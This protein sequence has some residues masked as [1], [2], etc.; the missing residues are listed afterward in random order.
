MLEFGKKV[1]TGVGSGQ[2]VPTVEPQSD[3][4]RVICGANIQEL[5]GMLGYTIREVR[6]NLKEILNIGD[7]HTTVLVNGRR[8]TG[9][10]ALLDGNEEL[11]F[12]KPAGQKG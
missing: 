5:D 2:E 9:E 10:G 12:K 11:E 3:K 4:L 6:S 7:D 1:E 8:V